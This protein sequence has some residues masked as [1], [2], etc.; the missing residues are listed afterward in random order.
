MNLLL[1]GVAGT[2]ILIG[3]LFLFLGALG[4]YRFPDVYN[5]LQ[6]GTK[7][8]TLGALSLILGVGLAEPAWLPKALVL[9]LFILLTNPVSSH[10]IGRASY[11]SGY[12]LWEGSIVDHC[13]EHDACKGGGEA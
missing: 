13:Q 3:S 7:S 2:L 5:R 8:T 1:Q 6:A 9:M 10:A 4:V 11:K 12:P